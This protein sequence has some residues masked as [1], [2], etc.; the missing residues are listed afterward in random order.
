MGAMKRLSLSVVCA[1]AVA[2]LVAAVALAAPINDSAPRI[3]GVASAGR[4]VTA[5]PGSWVG[6]GRITYVYKW[7]RCGARGVP[8]SPLK[9]N[10]RQ[11]TGSKLV[12]PKGLTG[13][14]RVSVYATDPGGT[15]GAISAAVKLR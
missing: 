7:L 6:T 8:C 14:L 15:T 12:V 3:V 2:L 10:G 9:K 1:V 4:T 5:S 11:V 13:M